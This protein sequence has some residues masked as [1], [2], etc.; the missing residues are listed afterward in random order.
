MTTTETK[1]I[2]V[3]T[4]ELKLHTTRPITPDTL[5]FGKAGLGLDSVDVLEIAVLLDKN[6]RVML[7]E[8]NEEVNAA[9]ATIGTLAAFVDRH[10]PA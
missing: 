3:L 6:F 10:Q 2:D 7:S 5:I 8:Q 1:L 4:R 9:L